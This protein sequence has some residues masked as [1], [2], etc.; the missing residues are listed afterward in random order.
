MGAHH[1]T[2][3]RRQ[4]SPVRVQEWNVSVRAG[5]DFKLALTVLAD[6][7]GD[8]VPVLAQV[9]EPERITGGIGEFIIG[10]SAIGGTV[11]PASTRRLEI[12]R[13]RMAFW[14]EPWRGGTSPDYG[15]GWYSGASFGHGA[16]VRA[17]EGRATPVREG[18][19]N[20][21]MTASTMAGLW[22]GRYR[23]DITIDLADGDFCQIE[24]VF[25]VRAPWETPGLGHVDGPF[26]QLNATQLG[27]GML[28]AAL[29]EGIPVDADGFSLLATG[30]DPPPPGPFL[31]LGVTRL[32]LGMLA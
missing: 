4:R 11:I 17:I 10:V 32:G 6:D 13:A 18:G 14:P 7:T 26:W 28:A 16:D 20:F 22:H 31:Q 25:Q 29:D 15:M 8:P 12:S 1:L 24:G 23:F 30:F 21:Q 3:V 9:T 2:T 19:V 5:E 27:L